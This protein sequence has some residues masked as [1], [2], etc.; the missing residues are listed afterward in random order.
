MSRIRQAVTRSS[1]E[2]AASREETQYQLRIA[3]QA[4]T[5]IAEETAPQVQGLH[6]TKPPHGPF[7]R[8]M[9]N[10]TAPSS[11]VKAALDRNQ[12]VSLQLWMTADYG[13]HIPTLAED[14]RRRLTDRIANM[15]DFR[16]RSVRIEITDVITDTHT[17]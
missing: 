4:I 11:G 5:K 14:L 15:T 7:T 2:Q 13:V 10:G 12:E 3:T 8:F 16:T 6:L 1:P 17:E 9:A